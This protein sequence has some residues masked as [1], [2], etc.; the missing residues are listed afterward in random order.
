M[1]CPRACGADR[2]NGERGV[3]GAGAELMVARAALHFWE[4]PPISGTAGSGTVFFSHCP[5]RCVYCQNFEIAAGKAG[6][7][8]TAD[9]LSDVFLEL[10]DQGANN[11]NLVTGTHYLPQIRYAV[12]AA[13]ENGLGVPIVYNTSGYETVGAVRSLAGVV[14]AYLTDFK[15]WSEGPARSY[16]HAPGYRDVAIAALDEMVA[17]TGPCI[18]REVAGEE[19]PMLARGTVVRHMML[20]GLLDDSKA[21][22]AFLAERY[23]NSITLSLMNQYTPLRE[24]AGH[25]ELNERVP[26]EDYEALLDF[27]DELGIEDYF[28]Q[29]GDA[30]GES[31]V[32]AFDGSGV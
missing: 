27:A 5:L 21:L 26:A 20:P 22:V 19:Q 11:V 18:Y 10:E 24:V 4:E 8:I 31:F 2:A 30:V 9:R 32:P 12:E 7:A 3:C 17:Q 6:K 15:Y 1:L 28:W 16:S 14:D 25:P 13:R 23:G 29:E